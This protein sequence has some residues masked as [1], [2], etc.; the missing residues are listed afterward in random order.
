LSTSDD[1][2]GENIDRRR[3]RSIGGAVLAPTIS[4][5][6]EEEGLG[7]FL[8]P[9]GRPGRRFMGMADDEAT[10]DKP[11]HLFLLLRMAASTLLWHGI[12]I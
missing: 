7:L 2:E 4:R 5:E 1:K 9:G 10:M 6:A 8:L 11:L 3:R 12:G